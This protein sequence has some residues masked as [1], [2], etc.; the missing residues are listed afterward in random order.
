MVKEE[1]L[2]FESPKVGGD[3]D[4]VASYLGQSHLHRCL[5]PD[6]RTVGASCCLCQAVARNE[7]TLLVG[8]RKAAACH[9]RLLPGGRFISRANAFLADK[10]FRP[11]G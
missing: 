4:K 7:T 1:S 9:S 3:S 2:F 6:C 10:P 11:A 8:F 5:T